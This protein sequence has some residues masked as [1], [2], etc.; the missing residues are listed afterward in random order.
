MEEVIRWI[1]QPVPRFF[2]SFGVVLGFC[3]GIFFL[4]GGLIWSYSIIMFV[5]ETRAMAILL[6]GGLPFI[7]LGLLL[8]SIPL[9]EWRK[10]RR[11][12]YLV[13]DKRAI[14]IQIGQRTT[15]KTYLPDQLEDLELREK[16]SGIGD[17]F[18]NLR[19]SM[20]EDGYQN[21]SGGEKI[22]FLGVRYP[23]ETEK[24]LRQLAQSAN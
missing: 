14:S 8:M 4:S 24:R 17:V 20:D 19:Q 23:K 3:S 9:G 16:A 6:L 13:T 10:A 11:T 1:E 2:T 12:A 22:G 5:G 7:G 21:I 15:T 18:I